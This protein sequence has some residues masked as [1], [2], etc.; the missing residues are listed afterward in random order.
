MVAITGIVLLSSMVVY[1][2]AT[3]PSDKEFLYSAGFKN[4]P[5]FKDWEKNV[6]RE[7]WKKHR[8]LNYISYQEAD[9][10]MQ[11]NN[12]IVAD[13]ENYIGNIP[14]STQKLIHINYEKIEDDMLTYAIDA[15]DGKSAYLFSGNEV[16]W[17][18][19]NRE[20]ANWSDFVI[21]SSVLYD[22]LDDKNAIMKAGCPNVNRW[23]MNR[24]YTNTK[25]KIIANA[26]YFAPGTTLDSNKLSLA[27]PIVKDPLAVIK[28]RNGYV[29]L[30]VWE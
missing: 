22:R 11:L 12:F 3:K 15:R 13:A 1:K 27:K 28:H 20:S 2:A 17:W 4:I 5:T 24:D 10:L 26:K 30:A 18:L 16:G 6:D 19:R 8:A 14:D 29:V 7:F 21:L 9:S 25:I 23:E